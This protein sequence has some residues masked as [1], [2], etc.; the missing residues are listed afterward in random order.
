MKTLLLTIL[1]ATI[2]LMNNSGYARSARMNHQDVIALHAVNVMAWT[3]I[4]LARRYPTLPD[5]TLP[6]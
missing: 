3:G 6:T 1:T 5:K 2:Q 4:V